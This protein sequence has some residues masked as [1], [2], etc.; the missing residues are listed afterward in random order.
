[1]VEMIASLLQVT[2]LGWFMIIG[3]TIMM[4]GA[5]YMLF[6]LYQILSPKMNKIILI[7]GLGL[8]SLIGLL[9]WYVVFAI[10]A[11]LWP[12]QMIA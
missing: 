2:P 10:A 12:F 4:V 11:S 5:H 6:R 3:M 8:M 7:F 9:S 1:M